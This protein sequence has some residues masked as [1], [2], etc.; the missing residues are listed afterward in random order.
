MN[1]FFLCVCAIALAFTGC[2]S[3][4]TSTALKVNGAVITTVDGAMK[5][6]AAYTQSGKGTAA[7]I[8][9]V[10][11]AFVL[12]YNAEMTASNTW[13]I[14]VGQTNNTL[15]QTVT[16]AAQASQNNLFNII[17]QFTQ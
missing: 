12:Y 6:W 10:S 14:A 13:V 1:R 15:L 9:A 17:S 7:Q 16:E 3:T 5:G 8:L 2:S 4:S 11:N